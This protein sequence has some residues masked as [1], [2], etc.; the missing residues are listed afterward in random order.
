MAT[1]YS[2][3]VYPPTF[4]AKYTHCNHGFFDKIAM[5]P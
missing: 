2:A 3:L 4:P 1:M 5:H